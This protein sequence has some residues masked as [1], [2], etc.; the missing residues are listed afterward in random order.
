VASET[1]DV[2]LE[3][4]ADLPPLVVGKDLAVEM[5]GA[6]LHLNGPVETATANQDLSHCGNV[7][8]HLD[9]SGRRHRAHVRGRYSLRS[10]TEFNPIFA[11]AQHQPLQRRRATL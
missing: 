1:V 3:T 10:G 2:V 5:D 11:G 9:M 7:R 8:A 6:I 4:P